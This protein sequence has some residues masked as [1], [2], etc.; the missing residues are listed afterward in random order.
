MN[1]RSQHPPRLQNSNLQT[2]LVQKYVSNRGLAWG[3]GIVWYRR[4]NIVPECSTNFGD[5]F[6]AAD[7]ETL[8][9]LNRSDRE[10]VSLYGGASHNGFVGVRQWDL[11]QL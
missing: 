3:R 11:V 1:T 9:K 8:A 4:S 6:I 7:D 5:H 10:K 2:I